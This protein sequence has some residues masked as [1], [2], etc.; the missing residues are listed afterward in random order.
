[1]QTPTGSGKGELESVNMAMRKMLD[2]YANV[3]L[4]KSI[5]GLQ[6]KHNNVDIIVIISSGTQSG[7]VLLILKTLAFARNQKKN[8]RGDNR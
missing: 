1:M 6:T 8:G 2:L 3:V 4:V 7:L 5:P